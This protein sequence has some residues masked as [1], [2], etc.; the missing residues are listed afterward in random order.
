MQHGIRGIVEVH[1][2]EYGLCYCSL[3]NFD[4]VN[5]IWKV[6]RCKWTFFGSLNEVPY[7]EYNLE[8]IS[9]QP[10]RGIG[11]SINFDTVNITWKEFH[12]KLTVLLKLEWIVFQ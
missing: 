6:L 11:A 9:Q 4:R 7:S 2:S 10:D 5:I 8:I 12:S 3:M 1:S